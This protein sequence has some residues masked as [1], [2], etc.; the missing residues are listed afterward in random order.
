MSSQDWDP[1]APAISFPNTNSRA[2]LVHRP[3]LPAETSPQTPSSG[4]APQPLS[5]AASASSPA[6]VSGAI[7]GQ[8]RDQLP[9]VPK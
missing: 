5:T 2:F 8:N 3:S 9:H 1:L 7:H 4:N 6:G